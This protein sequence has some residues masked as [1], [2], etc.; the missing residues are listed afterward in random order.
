MFCSV[1]NAKSVWGRFLL[2]CGLLHFS[3]VFS[4]ITQKESPKFS[5]LVIKEWTNAKKVTCV[6]VIKSQTNLNWNPHHRVKSCL[7]W[8]LPLCS[9]SAFQKLSFLNT[10]IWNIDICVCYLSMG[11]GPPVSCCNLCNHT[12]IKLPKICS[13]RANQ[14]RKRGLHPSIRTRTRYQ[15][16]LIP[17]IKSSLCASQASRFGALSCSAAYHFHMVSNHMW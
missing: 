7:C 4:T 6:S 16:Q 8:V 5:V 2:L 17:H 14:V 10:S 12:H 3:V 11:Q 15:R 9:F 13:S 1:S